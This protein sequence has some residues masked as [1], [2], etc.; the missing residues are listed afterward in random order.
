MCGGGRAWL[1]G[2]RGW[3]GAWLWGGACVAGGV[4]GGGACVAGGGACVVCTP[5]CIPRDTVGQCA[6]GTH[7]TG[8]HS[9]FALVF[10]FP[11]VIRKF[12]GIK[13]TRNS[14]RIVQLSLLFSDLV[15]KFGAQPNSVF[16]LLLSDSEL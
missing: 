14:A 4:H 13:T 10:A 1:G 16:H 8:M 7:P 3:G 6:G 12:Y 2:M 5:P 15:N 9:C 11:W